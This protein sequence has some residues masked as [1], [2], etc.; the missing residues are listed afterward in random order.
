[1]TKEQ[2]KE[3][4]DRIFQQLETLFKKT[5]DPIA[6]MSTAAAVLHHKFSY[7][8]WTGF[9]LLKHGELIVAAYQGPVACLVLERN[10]G[11][12]WAGIKEK[13]TIIVPDVHKFPG[14][15]SCDDRS[16]SEI[17]VPLFYGNEVMGIMDIDS[18]SFNSFDEIDQAGLEKIVKLIF[19]EET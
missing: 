10:K 16:R 1:M 13:K 14:H 4:Y 17:V 18:K 2:K 15:L 8:F 7:Y 5:A 19:K 11:V 3:R 9:Y 6:R 12:C